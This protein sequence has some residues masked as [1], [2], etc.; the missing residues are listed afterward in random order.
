[1]TDDE[2]RTGA[3]AKARLVL[4]AF[5]LSGIVGLAAVVLLFVLARS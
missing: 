5:A 2:T 3:D 4:Y 1:M